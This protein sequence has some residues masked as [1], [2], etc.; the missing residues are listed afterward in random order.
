MRVLEFDMN[1]GFMGSYK[2]RMPVLDAS[3][4]DSN[5]T[6][7]ADD[8]VDS[9]D[10][11]ITDLNYYGFGDKFIAL[12]TDLY[13]N[14]VPQG[15]PPNY[16]AAS[17]LHQVYPNIPNVSHTEYTE[18][19]QFT[20]MFGRTLAQSIYAAADG[21]YQAYG[22]VDSYGLRHR[23]Q[24]T[25]N[26]VHFYG[27]EISISGV[28]TDQ[29]N[30][31]KFD[32][33]G[34]NQDA[35]IIYIAVWDTSRE[36]PVPGGEPLIEKHYNYKIYIYG[37]S[38]PFGVNLKNAIDGHEADDAE[39]DSDDPYDDGGNSDGG[40][41]NGDYDDSS[42]DVDF[43][44]LPDL[45]AV[46]TGFITLFVPSLTQL[47]AL[48]TYMWTDPMFDLEFWRKIVANP[49]DAILGLSIIPYA[50][51]SGGTRN[52]VVGNISTNVSMNVASAQF[53][54]V[55][56]GSIDLTEYF[57]SYLD[58]EPYTSVEIYLPFIGT[59][60]L[61]MDELMP[62]QVHVKYHIDILSGACVAFVRAE[63]Q[64]GHGTTG[65]V[66]YTFQ[67]NCATEI[68]VTGVSFGNAVRSAIN[69]GISAGSIV[70]T[71]GASAPAAIG[72][73]ANSVMGCKP[74]V[75]KSN[76]IGASGGLMANDTPYLIIKRPNQCKPE[77][78]NKYLGY[79]SFVTRNLGSISGFTQME[80]VRLNN[81]SCNDEEMTEI[82]SLL[83]EGVIL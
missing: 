48:A 73:I 52:V 79:P 31:N 15:L 9:I 63:V 29:L 50:I 64:S 62:K 53:Y 59:R 2:Y 51:P 40:G 35:G 66:L 38:Y 45:S 16:D 55:D 57:G 14:R 78:Q 34:E 75:N 60:K 72:G 30:G 39:Q 24:T 80:S 19:S 65:A 22:T 83:K 41:G 58:Y 33:S 49:M 12:F 17:V 77:N 7:I 69:I 54:A 25:W 11:V 27:F 21:I 67:G 10:D 74:T 6:V 28:Y 76:S 3:Y 70:A 71:N 81:I 46:D 26:G 36:I 20:T 82:M 68:P 18:L 42:D 4:H 47:K 37:G 23:L 56:C 13:V 44:D 1:N 8:V 43:P 32:F 5:V 61:D